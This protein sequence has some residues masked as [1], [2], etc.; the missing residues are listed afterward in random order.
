MSAT[1]ADLILYRLQ[2]A[3]DTYL[4]AQI[5]AENNRWNSV[6][7]RL[8]YAAYYVISALLLKFDHSPMTHSGVKTLFSV[9]FIKTGIV[10]EEYGKMFSQLFLWRQK[11]DYDDLFDFDEE[12]VSIYF[13]PVKKLIEMVEI[14]IINE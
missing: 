4:D 6:I 11:G 3:K 2:R 13:E 9:H 14:Q 10:P 12:R 5:L 1:K 7:N 8:Y